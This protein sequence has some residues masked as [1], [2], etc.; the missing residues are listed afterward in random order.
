[1]NGGETR[2]GQAAEWREVA[3]WR[4]HLH[5]RPE[6]LYE[7]HETA[8]FVAEKLREF[9][10]ERVETGLGRTGVVGLV[11]GTRGDGPTIALRA[12]MDALPIEEETNLPWRSK[13]QGMM[14]ACG[15]DGHT[16]MLLGAARRLARSPDFRGAVALI[17]QPAEEGGAGA[18]AMIDDGLFE[19]FPIEAVYGMHN[20]PGMAVGTFGTRAGPIMAATDEFNLKIAGRGGHA[21]IPQLTADPILAG[22]ALVQALQQIASRNADPLASVVVSVTQFHGGFARNVIPET[23]VVSG[24]VRTLDEAT[25]TLAERRIRECAAGIGMGHGVE[26]ATEYVRH[27]PVTRNDAGQVEFCAGVAEKV[28]GADAVNSDIPPLMGG[29]DFSFMLNERPG[30]FVFIGNGASASLHHPAYDFDDTVIPLGVRYWET[31]V[32]RALG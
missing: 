7:T 16:A 31:L 27:Y 5:E 13:T 19:R 25:R 4:H 20:M 28:F 3:A 11:R 18:K 8:A 14:H 30:A 15:H 29:E 22:A 21:A 1:M 9:G 24:T 32:E 2:E 26:I 23:A 12:D 10:C 6:L 17:F